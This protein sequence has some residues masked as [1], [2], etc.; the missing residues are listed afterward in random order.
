MKVSTKKYLL[1]VFHAIDTSRSIAS[2]KKARR[3]SAFLEL[4]QKISFVMMEKKCVQKDKF[5]IR[6]LEVARVRHSSKFL[7][8]LSFFSS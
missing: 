8:I 2:E 1:L 6:L 3:K 5:L 7:K 4:F